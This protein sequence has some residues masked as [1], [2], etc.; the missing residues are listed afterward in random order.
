[1]A[2][3]AAAMAADLPKEGTFTHTYS[4]YGVA[5][6]T[7]IG[8]DRLL[9]VLDENGLT[10]GDGLTDHVRWHCFGMED[11]T[12]GMAQAQ[13][14][15]V[16]TDPGGDQIVID[17]ATDGK[18]AVDA[19]SLRGTSTF[20]TGTGKY[21]GISGGFKLECHAAE[22]QSAADGT[23]VNYCLCQGSYKLP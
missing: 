22:F 2:F 19:K 3:G 13:Y 8:K 11:A 18:F 4:S 12:K 20:T 15:C 6:A 1:M 5:K 21:A 9:V 7:Q 23:F 10:V 16:G 17:A 14:Y